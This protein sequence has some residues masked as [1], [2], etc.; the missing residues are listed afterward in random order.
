M[1][2]L[3]T[4]C[5]LGTKMTHKIQ[6]VPPSHLVFG[7]HVR[8]YAARFPG[9]FKSL[10]SCIAHVYFSNLQSSVSVF[11]CMVYLLL[12]LVDAKQYFLRVFQSVIIKCCLLM[13]IKHLN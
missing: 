8:F 10:K 4:C 13:I 2:A 5:L 9:I 7:H 3:C 6:C 11:C 12:T 1:I